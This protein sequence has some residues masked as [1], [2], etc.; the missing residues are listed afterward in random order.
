MLDV[1]N[2]YKESGTPTAAV[3]TLA[4]TIGTDYNIVVPDGED[5][6]SMESLAAGEMAEYYFTRT[7]FDLDNLP[8]WKVVKQKVTKYTPTPVS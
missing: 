2:T 8:T 3:F 6:A 1:V 5:L 7:A 4:G